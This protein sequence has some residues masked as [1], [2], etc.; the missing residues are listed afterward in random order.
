[1][2]AGGE[3][4]GWS[5]VPESVAKEMQSNW[6][7][8]KREFFYKAVGVTSETR[9]VEQVQQGYFWLWEDYIQR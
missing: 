1:M 2:H 9:L 3:G 7:R 8:G 6:R 4:K 5:W